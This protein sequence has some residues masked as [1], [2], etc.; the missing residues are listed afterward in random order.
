MTNAISRDEIFQSGTELVSVLD[1][2]RWSF[3]LFN[4]SDLFY[5]HG[6]D[7]AWDESVALVLDS[8]NL[9]A[10]ID[11]GLLSGRLTS[12]E[13]DRL[14][15]RIDKR[16]NQRQPLAYLTNKT[17]FA[18]IEFYIDE[19]AL[20]PRSPIAELI[21]QEFSP[22][23]TEAPESILD[24]CTGGGCIALACAAYNPNATVDGVDISKDALEV[25]KINLKKLELE[26]QV[27][28]IE[29][30]VYSA[31]ADKKYDLIVT[32]PPYVDAQD[33]SSLPDEFLHEPEL[34][35]A[36]GSD[37]LD[38]SRK[39]IEGASRHL[40]EGGILILEVGNSAEALMNSYPDTA[41]TWLDFERGGQGI[42]MLE[43]SQLEA[44]ASELT[45]V[46]LA[47]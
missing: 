34:A 43:K 20:I 28:F 17:R 22:W 39:I 8:L 18:N 23:L 30:D 1:F 47:L 40:N 16:L 11:K 5:G 2:I 37:G 29:S 9:P 25:A 35:L 33:M 4:G 38:C 21:E 10:D 26:S 36:S 12:N 41:F 45:R 42:C 15:D 6:T 46:N 14:C 32:N 27:K 13:R 24:L 31:I 19:R 44:L 7:N 3:S